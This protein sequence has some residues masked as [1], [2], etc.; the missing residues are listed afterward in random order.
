MI[1]W[2][3][4]TPLSLLASIIWNLS[5]FLNVSLGRFAPVIFNAMLGAKNKT[6]I[7]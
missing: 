1:F 2:N 7:D 3:F 4:K 6:K 5:E